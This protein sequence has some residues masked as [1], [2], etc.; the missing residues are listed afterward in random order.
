MKNPFKTL[1]EA[2]KYTISVAINYIKYKFGKAAGV[3]KPTTID[4]SQLPRDEQLRILTEQLL[5]ERQEKILREEKSKQ[6]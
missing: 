2:Y 3:I 6:L 5:K 4:I 1:W